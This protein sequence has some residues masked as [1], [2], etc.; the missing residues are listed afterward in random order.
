MVERNIRR[1]NND[2]PIFSKTLQHDG[3]VKNVITYLFKNGVGRIHNWQDVVD[4][5]DI[6]VDQEQ[7]ENSICELVEID[8]ITRTGWDGEILFVTNPTFAH[9]LGVIFKNPEKYNVPRVFLDKKIQLVIS[10]MHKETS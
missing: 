7:I 2:Y 1:F 9:T 5:F 10:F 8:F 3:I 6:K 4:D